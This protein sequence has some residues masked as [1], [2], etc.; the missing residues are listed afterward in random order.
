MKLK[1]RA[2]KKFLAEFFPLVDII[3]D[4]DDNRR[5][6]GPLEICEQ[7]FFVRFAQLPKISQPDDPTVGHHRKLLGGGNRV[8]NIIRQQIE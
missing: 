7:E 5:F 1:S 6:Y 4:E 8:T 2:R 3:T